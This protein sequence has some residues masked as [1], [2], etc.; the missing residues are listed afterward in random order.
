MEEYFS[1]YGVVIFEYEE[2]EKY[3]TEENQKCYR[4]GQR[5][6]WEESNKSKEEV[7]QIILYECGP[8]SLD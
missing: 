8:F 4:N 6:R 7:R 2:E 3:Y 1:S 5:F